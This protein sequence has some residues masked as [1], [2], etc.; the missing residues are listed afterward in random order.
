VLNR[1]GA[2]NLAPAARSACGITTCLREVR[3]AALPAVHPSP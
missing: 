3:A 2:T 1:G